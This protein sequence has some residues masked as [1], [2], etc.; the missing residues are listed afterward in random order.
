MSL[1]ELLDRVLFEL[2]ACLIPKVSG[3]L[4]C[5]EGRGDQPSVAGGVQPCGWSCLSGLA[6]LLP[7]FSRLVPENNGVAR[8]KAEECAAKRPVHEAQVTFVLFIW[9]YL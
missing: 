3:L 4:W 6:L 7:H 8:K 5:R 9:Q 2:V 1:A